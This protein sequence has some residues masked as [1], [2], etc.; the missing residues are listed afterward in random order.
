MDPPPPKKK[1]KARMG[2]SYISPPLTASLLSFVLDSDTY[3]FYELI[4]L[5]LVLMLA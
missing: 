1:K 2:E 4:V 5:K 3:N